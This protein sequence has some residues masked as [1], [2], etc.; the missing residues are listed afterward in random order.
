MNGVPFFAVPGSIFDHVELGRLKFIEHLG[1][2]VLHIVL[3]DDPDA[4]PVRTRLPGTDERVMP[5][6]PWMLAEFAE[7]RLR[8]VG[9]S[10]DDDIRAGRLLGLDRSACMERDP[11]SAYR[12]DW[13]MAAKQAGVSKSADVLK[14]WIRTSPIP[15]HPNDTDEVKILKKKL[16]QP[17]SL[18]RWMRRLET[19]SHEISALVNRSGRLNGQSQ[20]SNVLDRLVHRVAHTYLA[21]PR[22]ASIEDAAALC[23]RWWRMLEAA[24]VP[25]I[26]HEPPS[27]ETVRLRIRSLDGR[28]AEELRNGK[29]GAKKRF[30]AS[31]EPVERERPFERIFIDGVELEHGCLYAKNFPIASNKMKGVFGQDSYTKY[32][33][34]GAIFTGPYRAEMGIQAVLN[35]MVPTMV[36]AQEVAANPYAGLIYGLPSDLMYDNDKAQLPPSLVPAAVTVTSSAELAPAYLPNVKSSLEVFNKFVKRK[37]RGVR[38]QIRGPTRMADPTYD[39]IKAADVDRATYSQMIDDARREW[40][41]KPRKE[42]GGKSSEQLMIEHL[43]AGGNRLVDAGQIRRCFASTPSHRQTL[44][45]NGLVYDKIQYRWNRRAISEVLDNNHRN[46]RFANRIEGTGKVLVTIRVYDGDVDM[47]EVLDDHTGEFHPMWSTNPSYTGG[48]SRWE[49]HQYCAMVRAGKG[50]AMSDREWIAMKAKAIVAFD[51]EMPKADFSARENMAALLEREDIRRKSG[52]RSNDPLF[53]QLPEIG[54]VT[55]LGGKNRADVPTPPPQTQQRKAKAQVMPPKRPNDYGYASTSKAT[56]GE[57]N[58]GTGVAPAA[59]NDGVARSVDPKQRADG[60]AQ[61]IWD[62]D[63]G[64]DQ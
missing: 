44:T 62:D 9:N 47:I 42:F 11:K 16:P 30:D 28:T 15:S 3:A 64:D 34:P 20:L 31:G 50:G 43:L 37:L 41:N 55:E 63:E 53:A 8:D 10:S 13:A 33:F 22:L 2:W 57:A 4:G 17:R 60:P 21:T 58:Q 36:S 6:V 7:G 25:D 61:S 46:T 49:H 29:Y 32:L 14:Q 18:I 1:D 39:P 12:H 48:L 38:G 23:D 52:V 51:T 40:N 59:N 5:T 45:S 26:G 54:L 56:R 35:V 24:G 27:M 19:G